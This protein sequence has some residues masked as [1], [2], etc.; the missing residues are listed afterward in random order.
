MKDF[1]PGGWRAD[2][3]LPGSSRTLDARIV[4]QPR[5]RR[6]TAKRYRIA[7]IGEAPRD[8]QLSG[9]PAWLLEELIRAGSTGLTAADLPAGLRVS[10][11]VMKLRRAG[12]PIDTL[13]EANEGVYGGHHGR[14]RLA[15]R[16]ERLGNSGHD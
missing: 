9:R 2:Q 11:F 16:A 10:G 13:T 1:A 4:S 12:V 8:I 14:Y 3:G 5:N 7:S 15:C 6:Q